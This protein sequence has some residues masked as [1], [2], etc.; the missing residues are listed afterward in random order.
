MNNTK[1]IRVIGFLTNEVR[2]VQGPVPKNY[3]SKEVNIPKKLVEELKKNGWRDGDGN[4]WWDKDFQPEPVLGDD[5]N[6]YLC[7]SDEDMSDS[8]RTFDRI[9][10]SH[11][12][13]Q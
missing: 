1:E 12:M 6:V 2:D 4:L 3:L 8:S 13:I 9:L 10:R 7:L 11:K 5:G